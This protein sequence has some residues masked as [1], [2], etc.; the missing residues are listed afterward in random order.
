MLHAPVSEHKDTVFCVL[1]LSSSLLVKAWQTDFPLSCC[2]LPFSRDVCSSN[3]SAPFPYAVNKRG[4]G[5]GW[6]CSPSIILPHLGLSQI[7]ARAS[8]CAVVRSKE[9]WVLGHLGLCVGCQCKVYGQVDGGRP[10]RSWLFRTSKCLL[11]LY[12]CE[13]CRS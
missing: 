10:V 8:I 5:H 9:R 11:G 1:F 7:F 4:G 3:G 6:R 2:L 13:G 12:C